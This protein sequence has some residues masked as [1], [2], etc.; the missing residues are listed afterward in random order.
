MDPRLLR[1]SQ[2][3]GPAAALLRQGLQHLSNAPAVGPAK[4]ETPSTVPP[5]PDEEVNFEEANDNE[6][7]FDYEV[8]SFSEL[9]PRA[10]SGLF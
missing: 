5:L 3:S 2:L 4:A 7:F 10:D 6:A 8:S 9:L 1:A